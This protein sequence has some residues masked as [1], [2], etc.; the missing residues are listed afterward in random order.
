MPL[1]RSS[2]VQCA[3]LEPRVHWDW[4][5]S[6]SRCRHC[7]RPEFHSHAVLWELPDLDKNNAQFKTFSVQAKKCV[8]EQRCRDWGKEKRTIAWR[9]KYSPKFSALWK[10][11]SV[12]KLPSRNAKFGAEKNIFL[13]KKLGTKFKLWAPIMFSIKNLQLPVRI[14]SKICNCFYLLF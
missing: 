2:A 1:V 12:R 9:A 10:S 3:R 14:L 5:G 4:C 6:K 13:K 11:F 7:A 8:L